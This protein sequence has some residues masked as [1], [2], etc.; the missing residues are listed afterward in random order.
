M[1]DAFSYRVK[2]F[3]GRIP[4]EPHKL[5]ERTTPTKDCIV[6]CHLG[7]LEVSDGDAWEF[8]IGGM[9]RRPARFTVQQI[10]EMPKTVV[11]SVHQC[12]GSPLAPNKP[13]QRVCNVNWGGVRLEHVLQLL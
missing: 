10:K 9:V 5:T 11:S 7:V 4:S 8:E 13:T 1:S 6:L 3:Y 12:A 2:G